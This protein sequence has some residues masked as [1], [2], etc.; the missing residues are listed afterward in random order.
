[1]MVD[2]LRIPAHRTLALAALVCGIAARTHAEP[3]GAAY[4]F[5]AG[6]QRGTTV[7][8]R[9]GGYYL[10]DGADFRMAGSG[11][12]A[13]PRIERTETIWF[14][15]PVIPQPASQRKEDYPVDYAGSVSIEADADCGLRRWSAATEQGVTRSMPF[16]VGVYSE[17]VE[18][19]IDGRAI[20][21]QVTLPVTVNG[22]MF[23]REDVDIWTFDLE[24]G[25]TVTCVVHAAR[26][27]SPLDARLEVRDPSDRRIA[28]DSG[29]FGADPWVRFTAATTGRYA[30]HIHDAA[31][32]GLQQYVYRLSMTSGPYVD[33]VFPLGGRAGETITLHL[34][35]VNLDSTTVDVPLPS[36]GQGTYVWRPDFAGGFE[37][38]C[39]LD[40]GEDPEFGE[41][42][43]GAVDVPGVLNGRIDAPGEADE[44]TFA[45]RQSEPVTVQVLAADFGSL[46]D[47]VLQV[48]DNAGAV[49]AEADD[50]GS[51]VDSRLTFNPPA[52]GRYVLRITDRVSSRG[53]PGYAYRVR[54]TTSV[55]PDRPPF[56]V[57]LPADAFTI[58]RGGEL[59]LK[60][61]VVR[62]GYDGEISLTLEGLPEEVAQEEAV[63]PRGKTK[64]TLKLSATNEARI[65]VCDVRLVGTADFEG[66]MVSQVAMLPVSGVERL[67]RARLAVAVPTPFRF[68]GIFESKFAPRGSVYERHYTLERGG[69]EG[70]IAVSLADTQARHLQGVRGPTI[71]VPPGETEF[72]YPVELPP[73][74]EVGRTSRTCL[75]A[76]GEVPLE[77][78]R[79]AKV[80]YTSQAQADQIIVLTAPE[81]LSIV[82]ERGSVSAA[83]GSEVRLPLRIGRAPR[84][85][86]PVR[87]QLICPPHIS[88]VTAKAV[89]VAG[90]QESA[91]L[92]LR[93]EKGD[94][95]PF[96]MPL[97]VRAT[98]EDDRGWQVV[99]ED[100]IDIAR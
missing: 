53:G 11:I 7:P 22:R 35:G 96:N 82:C 48:L 39:P 60:V 40:V 62:S 75:M 78:G 87:V 13:A 66:T 5:P 83:P 59:Q 99:A 23:P 100:K 3:P 79:S 77:D 69:F 91:E 74:L 94:L 57:T 2:L 32:G 29:T 84:L 92:T 90:E 80:T 54:L 12:Q 58:D 28:E 14:E 15:G 44:W 52:D 26:L 93:F 71:V 51:S 50:E 24:A 61:D 49:V 63:V 86:N 76:V 72:D 95:G 42:G 70:P 21:Q 65:A 8:V 9:V 98:T 31:F 89:T 45:A 46:L 30:V 36:E 4:I 64:A 47:S 33:A 34:R 97:T 68:A 20:P 37:M 43:A 1:M 41:G 25:E 19:E 18:N 67:D 85:T 27:G 16:L 17:V 55:N 38:G 73:F 56:A 81:E 6:G 88:G 10:H